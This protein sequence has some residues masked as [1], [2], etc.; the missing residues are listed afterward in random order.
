MQNMGS[1]LSLLK[2]CLL[3]LQ[4]YYLIM[5]AII[6]QN[7]N[8]VCKCISSDYKTTES[9]LTYKSNDMPLY[10]VVDA[11]K[12]ASELLDIKAGDVVAVNSTGTKVELD[13]VEYIIFDAESIMG[14]IA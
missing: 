11:S 13:G 4:Q 8:V 3:F 6:P 10:E 14:K 12:K 1:M 7:K 2:A 9:G 5:K